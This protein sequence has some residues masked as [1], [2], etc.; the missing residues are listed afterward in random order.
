MSAPPLSRPLC[1]P[2]S[3]KQG[4]RTSPRSES[5][6][7][8]WGEG[9]PPGVG[10]WPASRRPPLVPP[11]SP[12]HREVELLPR[13]LPPAPFLGRIIHFLSQ[14]TAPTILLFPFSN[15]SPCKNSLPLFSGSH[16]PRVWRGAQGQRQAGTRPPKSGSHPS[17]GEPGP[18]ATATAWPCPSPHIRGRHGIVSGEARPPRPPLWEGMRP[19]LTQL[20]QL[21]THLSPHPPVPTP[22]CWPTC[23]HTPVP[24]P[25]CWPNCPRTHLSPHPPVP[26]PT[27]WPNCPR[28]H[29][30]PHPPVPTPTCRPTCAHTHRP[31]TASQIPSTARLHSCDPP[32]FREAEASQ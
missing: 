12:A 17:R 4:T 15:W 5:D 14:K 30:S 6:Q 16:V 10:G 22:T 21:P 1:F 7:R 23:A 19:P 29:L 13:L 27:C 18:P 26:T 3:R 31:G 8:A 9:P 28:T 24:T 2:R 11:G 20:P 25:T 32:S